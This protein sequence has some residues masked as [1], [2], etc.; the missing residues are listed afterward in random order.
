MEK[1]TFFSFNKN[2]TNGGGGK[3]DRCPPLCSPMLVMI[4]FM[5]FLVVLIISKPTSSLFLIYIHTYIQSNN[6]QKNKQ[7]SPKYLKMRSML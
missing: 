2:S 4:M 7:T 6:Q 5:L 3:R 1:S